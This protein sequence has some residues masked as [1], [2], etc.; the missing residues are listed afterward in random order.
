MGG[1][2]PAGIV[3]DGAIAPREIADLRLV[4]AIV[5]G[6]F[7]DKHNRSATARLLVI[8]AD[9][10]VGRQVWHRDSPFSNRPIRH[11]TSAGA[12]PASGTPEA[13]SGYFAART[14]GLRV[15]G[16]KLGGVADGFG[17]A[18]ACRAARLFVLGS[19]GATARQAR[20]ALAPCGTPASGRRGSAHHP[21][22]QQRKPRPSHP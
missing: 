17:E 6:E 21:E 9:P 2:V 19:R 16:G 7:V 8:E 11:P 5:V 10:V 1:R 12:R 22:A 13:G 4:P 14:G 20:G 18:K 3:G 15:R